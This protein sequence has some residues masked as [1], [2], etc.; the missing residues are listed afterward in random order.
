MIR[1]LTKYATAIPLKRRYY[2]IA[3]WGIATLLGSTLDLV[4]IVEYPRCGGSWIRHMLQ[5]ALDVKQYAMDR[6]LTSGTIVQTHSLPQPAIRKP[7]VILRDP[8]DIMVSFYFKKIHFDKHL[9]KGKA[10]S[11]SQFRH[12]PEREA[13]DDFLE[14]LK[15][16]LISPEHPRFHFRDF[17][18]AWLFDRESF[19]VKYEDCKQDAEHQLRRMLGFLD[20]AVG[21]DKIT[22]AVEQNSFENRTLRRSG[23]IRK[24]GEA[25]VGQ[26]E[27][28]GIVGD[29]K[30]VFNSQAAEIFQKYEG[31]TL[32]KLG[33]E[34]DAS[35]ASRV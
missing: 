35:W 23:K 25:E 14:F 29:W 16:H 24:P 2:Q 28:K 15:V 30:N 19:S 1:T 13:Q 20:K 10:F 18:K 31:G 5:D 32:I 7:I 26:F 9:R 34:P 33:Y 17:A 3:N 21:D 11:T 27:R 6:H 4:H 12:D 22:L 8:R